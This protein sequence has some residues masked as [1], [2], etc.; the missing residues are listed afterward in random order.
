MKIV[1]SLIIIRDLLA[2]NL[3]LTIN[4]A[5]E[6]FLSSWGDSSKKLKKLTSGIDFTEM[7]SMIDEAE[8]F[9]L[10]DGKKFTL[11]YKAEFSNGEILL[12]SYLP[13]CLTTLSIR[14]LFEILQY[15]CL[16]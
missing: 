7:Q 6:D 4:A 9:K 5:T 2:N 12:L 10:P 8:Q 13:S 16:T 15:L 11:V 14:I 1:K 3:Q